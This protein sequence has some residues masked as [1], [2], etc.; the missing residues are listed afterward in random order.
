MESQNKTSWK[1]HP[2]GP[3]PQFNPRRWITGF[4][5]LGVGCL[6]VFMGNKLLGQRLE[7]YYGLETFN[8]IWFTQVFIVPVI[9][10]IAVSFIYGLGGKWYAYLPPLIVAAYQ[11]Y[12]MANILPIPEGAQLM[13]MG[14]WG[15]VVILAMEAGGIGGVLGEIF[16]KRIYGRTPKHLLYKQSS[17]RDAS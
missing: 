15:F 3:K 8:P 13:P 12:E 17:D 4:I 7:L 9:A 5:A 16:N 2:I 10:G 14:W 6:I 1:G 11:Y